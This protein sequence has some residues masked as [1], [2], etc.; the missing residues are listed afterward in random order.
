MRKYIRIKASVFLLAW[1]SFFSHSIIPHNHID[2]DFAGCKHLVHNIHTD[3]DGDALQHYAGAN[4][5]VEKVCHL[6]NLIFNTIHPDIIPV[7]FK[8]RI[9]FVPQS[10][11]STLCDN[12][13]NLF[14]GDQSESSF[15]LR[16]PPL[17]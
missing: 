6:S 17:S 13:N 4:H 12:E 5:P 1:I 8:S 10:E 14:I 16:A 11:K 15:F 7:F 9:V 2:Y 3:S